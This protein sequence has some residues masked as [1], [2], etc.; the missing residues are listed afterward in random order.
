MS[1][2]KPSTNP[3]NIGHKYQNRNLNGTIKNSSQIRPGQ[4]RNY[5]VIQGDRSKTGRVVG[6]SV[7]APIPINT[8][9]LRKDLT[10][11]KESQNS[12][13]NQSN[14]SGPSE[15]PT[16]SAPKLAPWANKSDPVQSNESIITT[17]QS[18]ATMN[19][20]DM[21]SDEDD[22][23][24]D[25]N[26]QL[27]ESYNNE[28]IVIQRDE[29]S[30]FAGNNYENDS[31]NLPDQ[32][33]NERDISHNNHQLPPHYSDR[34]NRNDDN[35]VQSRQFGYDD[36]RYSSDN[37][38]RGRPPYDEQ[39]NNRRGGYQSNYSYQN[40]S[41]NYVQQP[42]N[43]FP[44]G[45][46]PYN[47]YQSN[48]PGPFPYNNNPRD[49][50]KREDGRLAIDHNRSKTENDHDDFLEAARLERE[51]LEKKK[52]KS[53]DFEDNKNNNQFR[54]DSNQPTS[55]FA[56]SRY[57]RHDNYRPT[58]GFNQG[59]VR[60][61]RV[62]SD[63]NDRPSMIPPSFG[64]GLPNNERARPV[65]EDSGSW[66]RAKVPVVVEKPVIVDKAVDNVIDK[67]I[68]SHSQKGPEKQLYKPI[69]RSIDKQEPKHVDRHILTRPT[70]IIH[71]DRS[72]S[73]IK[74]PVLTVP[75]VV[76]PT[77]DLA[78]NSQ[79]VDIS[80]KSFA[81]LFPKTN[82][83]V[84]SS[85]QFVAEV[86][87]EE[88]S[89]NNVNVNQLAESNET[90]NRN[91]SDQT[92]KKF[93]FD[94]RINKLVDI[95]TANQST[96][97]SDKPLKSFN[98]NKLPID[99]SDSTSTGVWVRVKSNDTTTNDIEKEIP[100]TDPQTFTRKS[101]L[102]ETSEEL[103]KLKE[104]RELERIA[105]GPRTQGLLFTYNEFNEIEQVLTNEEKQI[106][107]ETILQID[108][109]NKDNSDETSLIGNQDDNTNK[110]QTE[111][112]RTSSYSS[113]TTRDSSKYSN[114]RD[115]SINEELSSKKDDS[116]ANTNTSK[117][118]QSYIRTNRYSKRPVDVKT[119]EKHFTAITVKDSS[120]PL[121]HEVLELTSN[122]IVENS[123]TNPGTVEAG[124]F[125]KKRF[126]SSNGPPRYHR[127]S[128]NKSES[129]TKP[130]T[131]T[132]SSNTTTNNTEEDS[133]KP[134]RNR[135]PDDRFTRGRGR[136]RG[137]SIGLSSN[138]DET[139]RERKTFPTRIPNNPNDSTVSS[140]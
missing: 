75:P 34:W 53:N 44:Q 122:V 36:R 60:G 106:Q 8:P 26:V 91:Q 134:R 67:P 102:H 3:V 21:D 139:K 128:V 38:G 32:S 89:D 57:D 135:G 87:D 117:D 13:N 88:D 131:T 54:D 138:T 113:R 108:E 45:R 59:F 77:N 20:A 86:H 105:R 76:E 78:T 116:E 80:K 12:Y 6:S 107:N 100:P 136:G 17:R 83:D 93:I 58:G 101:Q 2:T 120:G 65:V 29:I 118:I 16:N 24:D 68:D 84:D 43:N 41:Q 66:E 47:N 19:W 25:N 55:H 15:E 5:V 52:I 62:G 22:D 115:R 129:D 97:K 132:D 40:Q 49:F 7:S 96:D 123:N 103:V 114:T 9:S 1:S 48:A 14:D 137:R 70:E 95:E 42:H 92:K 71:R 81:S 63:G 130:I 124:P 109:S 51:L 72:D 121:V 69:D 30:D 126:A 98:R 99:N 23:N 74:I 79:T 90:T 104:A 37:R 56:S 50:S 27:S 18:A 119:I 10:K 4:S 127:N 11:G 33:Y 133:E 125:L 61:N 46:R 110:K 94:H 112:N 31:S 35:Q 64:R 39:Y 28:E 140:S 82:N 73:S 85:N 111:V